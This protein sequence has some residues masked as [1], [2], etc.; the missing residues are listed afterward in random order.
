M[1]I[2]ESWY[3]VKDHGT[4]YCNL[5]NLVEGE[6]KLAWGGGGLIFLTFLSDIK[7]RGEGGRCVNI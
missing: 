6:G 3:A 7:S 2:S 5:Y 1:S 4:N